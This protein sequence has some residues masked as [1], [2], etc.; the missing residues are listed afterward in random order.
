MAFPRQRGGLTRVATTGADGFALENGTPTILSWT[1]PN[2]GELHT[3][4]ISA[5]L[6]VSSALTG[7]EV[8]WSQTAIDAPA[9][10]DSFFGGG[11]G[12]GTYQASAGTVVLRGN[13]TDT[14]KVTQAS[15]VTAGA[16][17]VYA[18]LWTS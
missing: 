7:G 3:V 1:A 18:E 16:A 14:V 12:T 5:A 17:V 9:W 10:G 6:A 15:A 4:F 11:V 13:G 8:A 2:D